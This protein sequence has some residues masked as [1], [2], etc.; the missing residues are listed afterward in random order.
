MK[1]HHLLNYLNHH[2]NR[3]RK[4]KR[5]GFSRITRIVCHHSVT[6]TWDN[7][8]EA[9]ETGQLHRMN[10]VYLNKGWPGIPYHYSIAPSG[11]VY[12][13]NRIGDYTWHAKGGNY[14]S[15]G[16]MLMGNFEKNSITEKHWSCFVELCRLI[17]KLMP[18]VI[19]VV[20]HR[21]VRGSATLCPGK[22]ISDKI[23]AAVL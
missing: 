9:E 12:K 11:S 4:Y 13:L 14:N 3:H 10:R 20:G 6:R 2:P 19:K 21:N 7:M 1:I 18:Q 5:R 8:L 15:I 17:N 23:L 16:I 22:Y